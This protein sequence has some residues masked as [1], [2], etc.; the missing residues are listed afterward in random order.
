MIYQDDK[1]CFK[2]IQVYGCN[3]ASLFNGVM[4]HFR[5]HVG[6]E[7][8]NLVYS[9]LASNKMPKF[10]MDKDC[11]I[12][13]PFRIL[14]FACAIAGRPT[15]GGWQIG[16]REEGGKDQWWAGGNSSMVTFSILEGVTK[17]GNPHFRLGDESGKQMFDPYSTE[18]E[19]V[20]EKKIIYYTIRKER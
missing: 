3:L 14:S 2:K 11:Y 6:P 7:Y 18:P 9:V 5:V 20:E 17:K 12:Y 16:G 4:R 10:C 15:W 1:L 8:L 13:R 19:I